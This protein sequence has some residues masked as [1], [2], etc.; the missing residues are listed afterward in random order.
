MNDLLDT[1]AIKQKWAISPVNNKR[2][3][4][5]TDVWLAGSSCDSDDIYTGTDGAVTLPEYDSNNN[6]GDPMY[7]VVYDTGAYQN[8]LAAQHCMLSSPI[9]II[10]ENGHIVVA[11]KRES[12]ED[13]GK[14]FG[15]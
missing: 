1:W 2:D 4:E 14:E 3:G 9:K 8:S 13:V 5:L 15:W 12:P 11:K 7:I 10:A 6:E